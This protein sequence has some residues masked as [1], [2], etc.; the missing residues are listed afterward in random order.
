MSVFTHA[1]FDNYEQVLFCRDDNI[2]LSGIIAIHSTALGPAA[3]GCR[4]HDYEAEE[5]ALADVLR[6][7]K[8]MSYKNAW[9]ICRL[10][11]ASA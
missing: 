11:A 3:G 9:S 1:A 8:G 10:A 6:L 5:A 4:M 2:G 7:S